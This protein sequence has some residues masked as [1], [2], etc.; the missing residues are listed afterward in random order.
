MQIV[1]AVHRSG[2]RQDHLAVQPWTCVDLLLLFKTL[3]CQQEPG[4]LVCS[5][6]HSMDMF[7]WHLAGG[8][9]LLTASATGVR[10]TTRLYRES[11]LRCGWGKWAEHGLGAEIEAQ[12]HFR[13]CVLTERRNP[14]DHSVTQ[15]HLYA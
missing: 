4:E 7:H 9:Q 15:L 6:H 5:A 8:Q 13:K 12:H 1:A 14:I 3:S 2:R 10:P 11:E